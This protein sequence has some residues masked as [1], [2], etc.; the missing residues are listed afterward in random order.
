MEQFG[1]FEAVAFDQYWI[2]T[3]P[4]GRWLGLQLHRPDGSIHRFALP[5]EMAQ[6][7]FTDVVG[8][9]DFMGQLLLAKAETGGSA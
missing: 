5:C 2:G 1:D 7:F 6:Q 3:S 8:T 9:I 4:D